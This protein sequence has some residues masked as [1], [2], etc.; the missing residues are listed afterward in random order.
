[1]RDA[2][3]CLRERVPSLG[4]DRYMAPDLEAAAALMRD[5]ALVRAAGLELVL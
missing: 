4:A 5:G 3:A 2:V 1:L